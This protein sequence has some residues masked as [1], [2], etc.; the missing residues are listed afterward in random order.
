M[1]DHHSYQRVITA[2]SKRI[3]QY[4]TDLLAC[5]PERHDVL[6]GQIIA[7]NWAKTFV[8]EEARMNFEEVE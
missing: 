2:L 8:V 7:L 4:T 1:A 3:D 6:R 5:G